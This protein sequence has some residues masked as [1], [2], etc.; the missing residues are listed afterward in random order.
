[1]EKTISYYDLDY[2]GRLKFSAFL[3]MV[4][5]AADFNATELGV[6]FLQLMPLGMSFVLQ[7]FSAKAL[8]LPEYSEEVLIRT[9][10]GAIERGTFIR[11]GD[12]LDK[13]SQKLIEWASLWLLFD[14]RERKIL[15]PSVLPVELSGL[16]DL[17][18]TTNPEKIIIPNDWPIWGQPFNQHT[19][20]VR[21]ADIDT[22]NHMNN[23]VY[24]DLVSNAAG[25]GSTSPATSGWTQFHINYLAETRLNDEI[26]ITA[27]KNENETLIT[28]DVSGR[29]SFTAQVVY[30]N[31]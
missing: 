21:H 11:K 5:I 10:P 19:H 12:M 13:K 15:R 18:V 17:G 6:G 4:H 31:S 7:R 24:G 20:T 8:R 25:G 3:R 16:G 22:N 29:R 27:R 1:L 23:A 30:T 28:G 14:I 9:W 2:R 26:D